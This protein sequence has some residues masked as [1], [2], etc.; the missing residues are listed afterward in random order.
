MAAPGYDR[1]GERFS[2]DGP[3]FSL[4]IYTAAIEGNA[5]G[6]LIR[7]CAVKGGRAAGM[8]FEVSAGGGRFM[9]TKQELRKFYLQRRDSLSEEEV[10]VKS[11]LLFDRVYQLKQ[12]GNADVILAY[13]SFGN[14]V[15]TR[16]F[17][18]RC[19]SDGKTVALPRVEKSGSKGCSLS[20]YCVT[21]PVKDTV[22]GFRGIFEPDP[23]KA[24][25]LDPRE[26]DLAVVPGIAFDLT[27]NR[28]GYGA[29]CYDRLLPLLRPECLKIG[30]AY[31]I[32]LADALPAD[33][34]DFRLDMIVTEKRTIVC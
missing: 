2:G 11:V 28:L 15:V 34:G 31:E 10:R 30:T 29:G 13:M 25:L 4:F 23:A 18:Y 17:I 1:F 26:P 27:G 22:P 8:G 6:L 32:Q 33:S 21:D 5:A 19:I 12:Y 3:V 24:R 7:D 9:K 14:E 16:P 20:V